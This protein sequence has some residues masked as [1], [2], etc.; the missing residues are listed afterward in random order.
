M[1][2]WNKKSHKP[3]SLG[4][5]RSKMAHARLHIMRACARLQDSACAHSKWRKVMVLSTA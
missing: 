5:H 2:V 3:S 1:A 4:Q